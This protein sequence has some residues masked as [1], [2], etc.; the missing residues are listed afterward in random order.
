MN[1]KG[2]HVGMILSFVLFVTLTFF[3]I[4]MLA[5]KYKESDA[6]R[7]LLSIIED[8]IEKRTVINLTSQTV[9]L[10]GDI[11]KDCVSLQ[12][13]QSVLGEYEDSFI[14]R[15]GSEEI[16]TATGHGNHVDVQDDSKFLKFYFSEIFDD[17]DNSAI[18]GCDKF[19]KDS[20]E[21]NYTLHLQRF[22]KY[23]FIDYLEDMI[24][25]INNTIEYKKLKEEFNLPEGTEFGFGLKYNNGTIVLA[26][27][28]EVGTNSFVLESPITYIDKNAT[29]YSGYI[30]VKVW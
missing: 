9:G 21:K 10:K 11:D 23:Y 4:S 18:P 2:S 1:K 27:E 8:E 16:V 26:N 28:K 14:V 30:R 15:N 20:T 17:V 12:A 3:L 29:L 6:K 19:E 5:P 25:K 24:E 13:F 7:A 22:E